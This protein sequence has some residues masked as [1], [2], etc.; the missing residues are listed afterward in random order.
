MGLHIP[1][2]DNQQQRN[3]NAYNRA[4][5][6][7]ARGSAFPLEVQASQK[8]E[9]DEGLLE[10]SIQIVEQLWEKQQAQQGFL[11]NED[12]T[13]LNQCREIIRQLGTKENYEA[14]FGTG[15]SL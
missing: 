11:S 5:P 4:N 6:L 1:R 13:V 8:A 15:N 3:Q 10:Q 14:M 2:Y 12:Q 7:T 9:P